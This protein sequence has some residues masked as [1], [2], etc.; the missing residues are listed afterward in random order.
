MKVGISMLFLNL[1]MTLTISKETIASIK[2][3][4]ND[5]LRNCQSQQKITI[6]KAGTIKLSIIK[7]KY[8]SKTFTPK[9]VT[10]EMGP[11]NS[12]RKSTSLP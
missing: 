12:K 4:K 3:D 10:K 1:T 8:L 9:T 7:K 2:V 11:Q 5:F 6:L